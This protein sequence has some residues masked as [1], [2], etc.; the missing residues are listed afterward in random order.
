MSKLITFTDLLPPTNVTSSV[1]SGG[2]LATGSTYFYVIQACFDAGTF[3]LTT[4]GRS[5]S[6]N[7]VS[8]SIT[9]SGS[10]SVQL[11]WTASSGAG[12]YRIY[13]ATSSG[14]YVQMLDTAVRTSVNCVG[15]ICTFTDTGIGNPGNS[16][17]QNTVHGKLDLSGSTSVNPFS[18]TDLYN[19]SSANGWGVVDRLDEYTYIVNSFINGHTNMFWNDTDKVIIFG[20][21]LNP[22]TT[23]N[24]T[25]GT[26]GGVTTA[27]G[28]RLRF[29][30]P[31]LYTTQFGALF[32]YKTTFDYVFPLSTYPYNSFI[33]PQ[34][35]IFNSGS[36]EYCLVNKMRGFTPNSKTLCFISDTTISQGDNI[37]GAGLATYTRVTSMNNSRMFQTTNNT[38]ITA[39][40][41]S[42][43]NSP[44]TL[45]IGTNFAVK[46]IN[47][48]SASSNDTIQNASSQGTT[49]DVFTYDLKVLSKTGTAI[50]GASAQLI[51]KN[52][53][54]IFNTATNVSGSIPR[55]EV[56]L[57]FRNISNNTGPTQNLSPF[58]LI[59]NST[60]Y[61]EYRENT[62][63]SSSIA[64][65]K[66]VALTETGSIL[67]INLL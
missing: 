8:S 29:K 41:V 63:Y 27:Q 47:S 19:S 18:I 35:M 36:V 43:I 62:V 67:T 34:N 66:T 15:G 17:Y 5:Q 53:S 50:S 3:A 61:N 6:S 1:T 16:F 40:N 51:D 60:G 13:R 55:Q 21:Y 46:Y 2:T 33:A 45:L 64:L 26:K 56:R 10:Q 54:T 57:L 59:V 14:S 4:N 39:S 30:T 48:V 25:F 44:G 42:F 58:T 23:G 52:G 49:E 38:Q 37:S 22:T 12:G 9:I 32:A 24:F 31:D 28:C 7:Q 20:D 11:S 65:E